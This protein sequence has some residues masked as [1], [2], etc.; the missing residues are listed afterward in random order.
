MLGRIYNRYDL[1]REERSGSS[2]TVYLGWDTALGTDVWI[3]EWTPAADEFES[4][5]SQFGALRL[6]LGADVV[7]SFAAPPKLYVVVTD[8]S[9]GDA[10]L[11]RLQAAGLFRGVP[12][13]E[14]PLRQEPAACSPAK[15]D[16]GGLAETV[17]SNPQLALGKPTG[18]SSKKEA[19]SK[20]SR[21]QTYDQ[22]Q[23]AV[24]MGLIFAILIMTLGAGI[25][26][27][28]YLHRGV[29]Q[30][31]Y[32]PK[33]PDLRV[34]LYAWPLNMPGILPQAAGFS[35]SY[36][37]EILPDM[38]PD[39]LGALNRT[40]VVAVPLALAFREARRLRARGWRLVWIPER[41]ARA[42]RVV[43]NDYE[44]RDNVAY[45]NDAVSE[46]VLLHYLDSPTHQKNFQS[47]STAAGLYNEVNRDPS[48]FKAIAIQDPFATA[49]VR[50]AGFLD[51]Q[52]TPETHLQVS[53]A[54]LANMSLLQKSGDAL[55]AFVEW[56]R[57][58]R[59]EVRNW[60]EADVSRIRD[61]RL[62]IYADLR[63]ADQQVWHS[64]LRDVVDITLTENV[65]FLYNLRNSCTDELRVSR[66]VVQ[67]ADYL[68]TCDGVEGA[69][70]MDDR[71]AVELSQDDG[72]RLTLPE[73]TSLCEIPRALD[74][75]FSRRIGPF[76]LGHP[77]VPTGANAN[78]DGPGCYCVFGHGDG[79]DTEEKNL[80]IGRKRA[81]N[82]IAG[83]HQAGLSGVFV[84]ITVGRAGAPEGE[85]KYFRFVEVRRLRLHNVTVSYE[86]Q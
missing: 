10:S 14:P 68:D 18:L 59:E 77:E 78:L 28:R 65:E 16:S 63:E 60:A 13:F 19:T 55:S 71:L 34:G 52:S 66:S 57:N 27:W 23:R 33:P 15:G 54:I 86:H 82:V 48:N 74:Q 22:F 30:T 1:R 67:N 83:F 35:G 32:V 39:V 29:E 42:V 3:Y 38:Y 9:A 50:T 45:V 36:K 47:Y 24:F 7:D 72:V 84:P 75:N 79:I 2:G 56:W 69:R 70:L 62:P 26:S 73:V 64:P 51:T 53:T 58:G 25:A 43:V 41:S 40:D 5:E 49:L 76:V 46:E 4:C 21:S 11:E 81:E 17:S 12:Q 44:P 8:V 61:L 31:T 85:N 20:S 6:S 80:E 37:V